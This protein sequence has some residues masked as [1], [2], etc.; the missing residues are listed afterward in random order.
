MVNYSLEE[1]KEWIETHPK[2]KAIGS[3]E[4]VYSCFFAGQESF[5]NIKQGSPK[6]TWDPRRITAF[7]K[8]IAEV[9]ARERKQELAQLK[10]K[11]T[12]FLNSRKQTLQQEIQLIREALRE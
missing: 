8:W 11:L 5:L 1:F 10:Q 6:T 12:N 4:S 9:D 2:E 3:W 7:E